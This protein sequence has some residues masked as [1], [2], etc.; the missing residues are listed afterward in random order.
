MKNDQTETIHGRTTTAEAK[1]RRRKRKKKKKRE[2]N[3]QSDNGSSERKER[4][5]P[6]ISVTREH[7][8]GASRRLCVR[9]CSFVFLLFWKENDDVASLSSTVGAI[10]PPLALAQLDHVTFPFWPYDSTGAENPPAD[11]FSIRAHSSPSPTS[12]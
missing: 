1:I 12:S 4:K 7:G 3:A 9:K 2:E 11:R 8:E 5:E 6:G 10:T